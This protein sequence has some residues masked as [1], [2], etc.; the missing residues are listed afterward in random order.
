MGSV[1][2][3]RQPCCPANLH[4]RAY[5][6]AHTQT[7]TRWCAGHNT[8]TGMPD[9]SHAPLIQ[10]Q[11]HNEKRRSLRSPQPL[12]GG[13]AAL[14]LAGLELTTFNNVF[15][16]PF[17]GGHVSLGQRTAQL[18]FDFIT[19]FFYFFAPPH[20]KQ[21]FSEPFKISGSFFLV[22]LHLSVF[23][24]HLCHTSSPLFPAFLSVPSSPRP[25]PHLSGTSST[26]GDN[27]AAYSWLAP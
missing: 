22:Y 21:T 25:I 2:T 20:Y 10:K 24:L 3:H 18:W 11:Q 19:F 8:Y 7:H 5:M 4:T 17:K 14:Q 27:Y 1:W 13:R 26:R 23:C 12:Q 6:H 15:V 9:P 16:R